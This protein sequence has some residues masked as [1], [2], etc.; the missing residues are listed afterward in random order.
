MYNKLRL[1]VSSKQ[2]AADIEEDDDLLDAQQEDPIAA[3]PVEVYAAPSD[4]EVA[5]TLQ[6]VA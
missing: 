2:T 5:D 3:Q 6:N 4:P 1:E